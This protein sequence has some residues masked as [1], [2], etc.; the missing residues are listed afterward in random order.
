MEP[1]LVA[2]TAVSEKKPC[3]HLPVRATRSLRQK[4]S[5]TSRATPGLTDI[6]DP[7][8]VRC[9][10]EWGRVAT[11]STRWLIETPCKSSS[12]NNYPRKNSLLLLIQVPNILQ[13][14]PVHFSVNTNIRDARLT[15]YFLQFSTHSILILSAQ[16]SKIDIYNKKKS[17]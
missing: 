8:G 11:V 7:C 13:S 1:T 4:S 16:K 17:M 6:N 3:C 10:W 12:T 9:W 2:P 5:L 15:F 14:I